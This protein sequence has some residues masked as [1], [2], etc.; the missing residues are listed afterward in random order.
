[1]ALGDVV[2]KGSND[3]AYTLNFGVNAMCRLEDLDPTHRTYREILK[4]VQSDTASMRT[5]RTLVSAALEAP[6]GLT[7]EQVG[8]LIEDFGG[9]LV[10]KIACSQSAADIADAGAQL[11]ALVAGRQPAGAAVS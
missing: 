8:D 10:V 11:L 6:T 5:I 3:K 1:M 9:V 7:P 4:E 2:L